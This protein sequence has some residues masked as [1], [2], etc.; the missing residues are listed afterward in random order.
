MIELSDYTLCPIGT[1]NGING[2]Y[3]SLSEGDICSIDA[4]SPDD[5][6]LLLKAIAT[7]AHPVQGTYMFM[8]KKLDF[9]N[10]RNLLPCKKQIGYMTSDTA[11]IS[12]LSLRENFLLMRHYFEDSLSLD[13]DE[14]TAI[15]CRKL[16]IYDKL[17][18]R[19]GELRPIE[20]RTAIAIRELS[21]SP[22]MLL[23]ERPEDFIMFSQFDM[24]MEILKDSLLP[25]LPL[26]FIS[27]DKNF[28]NE[29]SN[30]NILIS[31]G[32]LTTVVTAGR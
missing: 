4:D 16:N 8:G 24:F 3:F 31:E 23:I 14:K 15:L 1:G 5:A 28:I 21:K 19:P 9:S 26:V 29:F 27:Y 7:L 32:T 30:R 10:Y 2:F 18:L 12:N 22:A 25:G 13:I 11:L 6:N 17:D 20:L